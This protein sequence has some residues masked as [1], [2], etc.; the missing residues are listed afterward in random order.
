MQDPPVPSHDPRSWNA[1]LEP[2]ALLLL[3]LSVALSLHLPAAWLLVPLVYLVIRRRD[4]EEY[5]LHWRGLGSPGFHALQFAAVFAPYLLAHYAYGVW[6]QGR[7]FALT[8]PAHFPT[9]LAEQILGI[10]LAEEFFFRAYLQTEIDRVFGRPWRILGTKVG[11]G[12]LAS[13]TIFAVCH[14]F[15]GGPARLITFFP[16]LWYGWLWARTGNVFVLAFYHGV[17]NVL[18]SIMLTS[19][20]AV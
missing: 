17:S 2:L 1:L 11:P 13:A 14:I 6:W 7:H 3:A 10:G 4:L 19:L 5:G 20:Q 16:G 15:H 9:L 18:M 8:L 12:W